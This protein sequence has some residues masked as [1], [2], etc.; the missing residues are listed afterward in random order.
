MDVKC[1]PAY[2]S[3][4]MDVL[5]AAGH[6]GYLV[7]GCLRDLLLGIEPH[8]FDMT[9]DASPEQMCEIFSAYRCIPTGL[10]HGTLTVLCDGVPVE[11]TT[12]R[13][14]GSY[15]DGR[16]PD[17]VSFT[18][19]LEEDLARRDFTVNAMAWGKEVGTVDLFGGKEDLKNGILRAVGDPECRF[20]EDALRI[21]RLFR[22][23]AQLDFEID[24]ETARG[25]IRAGEDLRAISAERVSAE[26]TRLLAGKAASRGMQAL[27]TCGCAPFVFGSLTPRAEAIERLDLMPRDA[28][29]RLA[30]LI[31]DVTEG[32]ARAL[33]RA[34]RTSND[35][36]GTVCG[37]ISALQA[38]LPQD[39]YSARRFV[40]T[41]FHTHRAALAVRACMGEQTE[42]AATLCARVVRDRT[43]VDIAHLK[44]NGREL[45]E[46]CGVLLPKTAPMLRFLQDLVWQDPQNNQ[47][48]RL[49][50]LASQY[51]DKI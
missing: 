40:C 36:A 3:E 47:K 48:E 24:E 20:R 9:T 51:K 34:L 27:C 17:H 4:L 10:R 1:V 44:V 49:L 16:R 50:A 25:A 23:C 31:A 43:A 42:P 18:G 26:I 12:H 22:F 33:C 21:L 28:A 8:D 32:E 14:D 13:I 19:K 46:K 6:R 11:I 39:E 5:A 38:P 30:A 2:I 41:H 7:G 37:V 45:Q 15:T 35:F 29:V